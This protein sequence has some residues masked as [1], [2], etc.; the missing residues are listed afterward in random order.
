MTDDFYSS[1]AKAAAE[2]LSPTSAQGLGQGVIVLTRITQGVPDPSKPWEPVTPI[3]QTEKLDGAVKGVSS[4]LVGTEAGSAVILASD[5]EAICTV[6]AMSYKAGDM[7]SIDGV[8]CV[9]LAAMPIPAAGTTVAL[10]FIV[11]S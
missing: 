7:L 2:L 11:R 8:D 10:R 4:Q 5:R 1:M 3:K 9:I 6:P